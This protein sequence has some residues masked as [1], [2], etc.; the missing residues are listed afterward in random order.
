MT[1]SKWVHFLILSINFG[2]L[3]AIPDREPTD[4]C[5]MLGKDDIQ[6]TPKSVFS[7]CCLIL[8]FIHSKERNMLF[9]LEPKFTM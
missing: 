4:Y 1:L 2:R 5:E 8:Q 3:M 6:G 7:Y 9:W